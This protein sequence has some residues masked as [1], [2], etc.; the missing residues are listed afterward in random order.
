MAG[1]MGATAG[2][3]TTPANSRGA[4]NK[5]SINNR[6]GDSSGNSHGGDL[7]SSDDGGLGHNLLLDGDMGLD[8]GA[9]L[10]DDI[11]AL[12]GE[13]GLRHGLGL[14]GALLGLCALLL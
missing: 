9:D 10:G 13:A 14:S 1:A 12:G 2:A 5:T 8:L 11:L 6:G 3:A 4:S 7:G